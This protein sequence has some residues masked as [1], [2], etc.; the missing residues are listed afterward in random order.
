MFS[1]KIRQ[2]LGNS[3]NWIQFHAHVC[4][5]LS[6]QGQITESARIQNDSNNKQTQGRGS[7]TNESED[8]SVKA[9]PAEG[10]WLGVAAGLEKLCTNLSEREHDCLLFPEEP[11]GNI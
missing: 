7:V 1:S 11:R 3:D 4:A 6:C 8:K 5:E 10:Q 2:A 9:H